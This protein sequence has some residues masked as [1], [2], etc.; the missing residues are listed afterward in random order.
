MNNDTLPAYQKG[1][2]HCRR[3]TP[4]FTCFVIGVLE[5]RVRMRQQG[6]EVRLGKV[7][8]S[9]RFQALGQHLVFVLQ[10][11]T[12]STKAARRERKEKRK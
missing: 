12:S 11:V 2:I 10:H 8:V 7:E 4:D 9:S 3:Q 1:S 6:A 5:A